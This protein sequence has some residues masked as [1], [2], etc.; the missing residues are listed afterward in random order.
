MQSGGR[1]FELQ[2][3]LCDTP[4]L[5]RRGIGAEQLALNEI[6]LSHS[7]HVIGV[8][9]LAKGRFLFIPAGYGEAVFDTESIEEALSFTLAHLDAPAL[10]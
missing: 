2:S 3:R 4:E 6:A 10:N 1:I 8:W 5:A 7:G 9:R